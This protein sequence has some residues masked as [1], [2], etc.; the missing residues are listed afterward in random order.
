MQYRRW[1]VF[2][3]IA[4]ALCG[5]VPAR[6]Q[7][8]PAAGAPPKNLPPVNVAEMKNYGLLASFLNLASGTV[9]IV[10][11]VSPSA[12]ETPAV[13]ETVLAT[14]AANPSRRLRAYVVLGHMGPADTEARALN[15]AAL[16][17]EQRLTCIWDPGAIAAG[18]FRE[19]IGSGTEPASGVCML[20]D[21][22]ARF[23]PAPP[24]P[25]LWM[26]DNPRIE[27]AAL[28][29]KALGKRAGEM[30]TRVEARAREAGR[31]PH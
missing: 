12:P 17:R 26:S 16:Y 6:G 8:P 11:I 9:R 18:M 25:D 5:G 10:A 29:G 27:G 19:A 1:S 13:M 7:A 20:Y 2:F 30:V 21:T 3:A 24:A 14:L 23:A 4:C 28:D 31:A 15:V 22:D